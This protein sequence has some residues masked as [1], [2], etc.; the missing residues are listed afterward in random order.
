MNFILYYELLFSLNPSSF[1]P[2]QNKTVGVDQIRATTK[3]NYIHQ[4]DAQLT[5]EG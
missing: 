4:V 2:A 1:H 3:G 5:N